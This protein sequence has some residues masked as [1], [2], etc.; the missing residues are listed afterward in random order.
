MFVF[1]YFWNVNFRILDILLDVCK[2]C[3]VTRMELFN[4]NEN[5]CRFLYFWNAIFEILNM[6]LDVC[7]KCSV[8]RCW[9]FKIYARSTVFLI[10]LNS[11]NQKT[12][13]ANLG[14]EIR[15][16]LYSLLKPTRTLIAKAIGREKSAEIYPKSTFRVKTFL[17]RDFTL[18][19]WNRWMP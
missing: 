3:S 4:N 6:S 9:I 15:T 14:Y 16:Q 10:L 17:S 7:K 5:H 2:K 13:A 1:L 19:D 12:V 11:W 18:E 8:T